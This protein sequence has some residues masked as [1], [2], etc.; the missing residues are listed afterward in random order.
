MHYALRLIPA[1]PLLD[2]KCV[3]GVRVGWEG[4]GSD[5]A[6]P[7]TSILQVDQP[8]SHGDDYTHP[9]IS[10]PWSPA[11]RDSAAFSYN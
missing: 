8:T 1:F 11:D 9:G 2:D 5:L 6:A 3:C 4:A 10:M 7:T